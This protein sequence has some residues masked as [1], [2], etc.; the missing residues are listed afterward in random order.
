M[1]DHIL[2]G[3]DVPD[4]NSTTSYDHLQITSP[5]FENRGYIVSAKIPSYKVEDIV[6]KIFIKYSALDVNDKV[7]VK[8][9]NHDIL[10]IPTSTPQFVSSNNCAWTS[11]TVFTTTSNLSSVKT[12]L[13]AD[14]ANACEV[15]IIS[16]AGA[17]SMAQISSISENTGTYTVTLAE[18]IIGA[19]SGN[20]C[21]VCIDNWKVLPTAS[22]QSAITYT[23]TNGWDEFPL[24]SSANASKWVMFKV[25]LRGYRTRIEELLIINNT[26]LDAK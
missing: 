4:Y 11:S 19:E 12:Y 24:P 2:F 22:G 17:G 10:N 13:D 3:S 20:V 1:C 25:E 26:H 5:A 8:Y 23:N 16:G 9:K 7:I 21:N 18:E 6:N 14:T 15:E